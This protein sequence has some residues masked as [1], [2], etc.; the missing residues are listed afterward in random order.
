MRESDYD[1]SG[2]C[3]DVLRHARRSA[4]CVAVASALTVL[5]APASGLSLMEARI[6][7]SL[8][9]RLVADIPYSVAPG[10]RLTSNC[11]RA[12]G[13]VPGGLPAIRNLEFF[14]DRTRSIISVKSAYPVRE[15]LASLVVEVACP[16]T[17]AIVKEYTV[18]LDPPMLGD[19]A[20]PATVRRSAPSV[21]LKVAPQR[22]P[23]SQAPRPAKQSAARDID[24]GSHY[25]VQVGDS[26]SAIAYRIKQRAPNTTWQWA[27]RIQK[28]N[29][30]AFI[31][32][33]PDRLQAGSLLE[34]P[35]VEGLASAPT[36]REP[37]PPRNVAPEM[38]REAVRARAETPAVPAPIHTVESLQRELARLEAERDALEALEARQALEIHE[39]RQAIEQHEAR[40]AGQDRAVAAQTAQPPEA[41]A[42]APVSDAVAPV[43][44]TVEPQPEEST[45]PSTTIA[46]LAVS[47]TGLI[48]VLLLAFG[49]GRRR[50][51]SR[52]PEP[53]VARKG[54]SAPK[55][56][57]TEPQLS[58]RELPA[59]DD[60]MT[61]VEIAMPSPFSDTADAAP[62]TV[63]NDVDTQ[64]AATPIS[65]SEL[66]QLFGQSDGAHDESLT[67]S[68][69]V[70]LP[71]SDSTSR[72][73]EDT[74]RLEAEA[75]ASE[76]KGLA[77]ERE[78]GDEP[79]HEIMLDAEEL[80]A[81]DNS[82]DED[83]NIQDSEDAPAKT[84]IPRDKAVGED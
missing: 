60:T 20:P 19:A 45:G 57:A 56:Q 1:N 83:T 15:P 65:A 21:P 74:A 55:A 50:A 40:L 31:G 42:T 64:I 28:L 76:E 69:T 58:S 17:P 53:Q 32:G 72:S 70:R 52:S 51:Y 34:I 7:S 27:A 75:V 43:P 25:R 6:Q 8:G 13:A 78:E 33:D 16:G 63:E 36:A 66:R 48:A 68:Q 54:Q 29:P 14:V 12:G 71:D 22:Q 47:V 4:V 30:S 61:V 49:M 73:V 84:G 9:Q 5:A 18:S 59:F 35:P 77:A 11:L 2:L 62:E 39:A 23:V 37:A 46:A 26:L 38:P 41:P 10:E 3:H 79:T 82:D 44:A 67:A 81:L 24:A 80:A